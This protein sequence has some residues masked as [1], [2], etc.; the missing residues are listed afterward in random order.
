LAPHTHPRRDTGSHPISTGTAAY[1]MT[2]LHSA[3]SRTL[4]SVHA[5]VAMATLESYVLDCNLRHIKVPVVFPQPTQRESMRTPTLNDRTIRIGHE[6]HSGCR[7]DPRSSC[8][9]VELL[10]SAKP[11][12]NVE[13]F[14]RGFRPWKPIRPVLCGHRSEFFIRQGGLWRT[15]VRRIFAR[16]VCIRMACVVSTHG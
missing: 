1:V 3:A 5:V 2:H 13:N 4:S 11:V 10:D 12:E 8:C 16:A 14:V 7:L 15:A 6:S 9:T